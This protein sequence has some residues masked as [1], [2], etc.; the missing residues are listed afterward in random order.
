MQFEYDKQNLADSLAREE[1]EKITAM[2]HQQE[3][4]QQRTFMYAGGTIL[5]LVIIF[6]ISVLKRLKISNQQKELIEQQNRQHTA[7]RPQNLWR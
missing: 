1:A 7:V 3:V 5:L 4:S 6:S 2:E